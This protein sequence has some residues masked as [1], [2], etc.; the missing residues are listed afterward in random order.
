MHYLLRLARWMKPTE[1]PLGQPYGRIRKD[2][3]Y[4]RAA[5]MPDCRAVFVEDRCLIGVRDIETHGYEKRLFQD[6][7]W[8]VEDSLGEPGC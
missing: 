5:G 8:M 7:I 4:V 3:G 1:L 2:Y 6:A